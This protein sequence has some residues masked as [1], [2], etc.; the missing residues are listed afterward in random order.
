MPPLFYPECEQ[1]H[2]RKRQI[3]RGEAGVDLSN[4]WRL[5]RWGLPPLSLVAGG[6]TTQPIPGDN[7]T[8][9]TIVIPPRPTSQATFRGP[10]TILKEIF[11]ELGQE[12][13]PDAACN[14]AETAALMDSLGPD[15]CEQQE[16][17][18]VER[19]K[20]AAATLTVAESVAM[21]WR[22]IAK[23]YTWDLSAAGLLRLAIKRS[24]EDR[25]RVNGVQKKQSMKTWSYGITTTPHRVDTLLPQT[26]RSLA[27]AGFDQPLL[28]IDRCDDC[29]RYEQFGLP[30][31]A[32]TGHNNNHANWFLTA[33]EIFY[34]D[35]FAD[36]YAIFE[37]DLLIS[38]GAREYLEQTMV[39]RNAYYS[40]F[41]NPANER[42]PHPPHGWFMANQ[43]GEG[44]VGLVFHKDAFLS[45]L[46]NVGTLLHARQVVNPR[47]GVIHKNQRGEL[48]PHGK[49]YVD[50]L[51]VSAMHQRGYVEWCHSPSIV[52]HVGNDSSAGHVA[53][54]PAPSFRGEEFD[55]RELLK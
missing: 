23:G 16:A 52:Q 54:P 40:L 48:V 30:F 37:D 21:A 34:R 18:L 36:Y 39:E 42:R 5:K 35:P 50:G 47:D 1:F 45:L 55:L 38:R 11:S 24:R 51:I 33:H 9:P 20:A 17:V 2:G 15:G 22:G 14:C 12:Y 29:R 4:Q 8:L 44:A 25:D 28:G 27:E 31:T 32:H 46:G 41:T 13:R 19:L 6:G 7:T 43:R 26:I 3:C 10:G 49:E 53:F